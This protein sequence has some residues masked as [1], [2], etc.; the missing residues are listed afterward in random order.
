MTLKGR[1]Y[2]IEACST[3]LEKPLRGAAPKT[4]KAPRGGKEKMKG[5]PASPHRTSTKP[6]RRRMPA[7]APVPRK[8]SVPVL[9]SHNAHPKRRSTTDRVR[10]LQWL[11]MTT[12]DEV[13]DLVDRLQSIQICGDGK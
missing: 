6:P 1:T 10:L 13:G 9:A 3:W 12:K 2:V 11:R 5:I 4:K 8:S 7:F